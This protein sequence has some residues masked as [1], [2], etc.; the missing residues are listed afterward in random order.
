MSL[1]FKQFKKP[2]LAQLAYLVGDTKAGVAAIIDPCRDIQEYLDAARE[3]GLR[4]T[5]AIETHI[6]ADF[7]SGTLEM[8]NAVGAEIVGGKTDDYEF[9]L[10]QI[11]EGESIE[12]GKVRLEALHT[13]GHTPEHMSFL[14]FD[15]EQGEEPVGVFTGDT[16]FNLDVGRPDLVGDDGGKENARDLY[17][18]IF[19][20]LLPLGDRVE[21]YPCHGAGSACGKSIGD[22]DQS[23]IGNEKKFSEALKERTEQEFVDWL[24]DSMPEPPT[25]YSRL[26]KVNAKGAALNGVCL[27]PPEPLDPEKFEKLAGKSNHLILDTR[28]MLA[29]G[30]GHIEGALNIPLKPQLVSWAGWMLDPET[31]LLLIVESERDVMPLREHLFRIGIDKIDGYLHSGMESWQNTAR[32]LQ[33]IKQWTVRELERN[34]HDMDLT[35]LDVRADEEWEA[36]RIPGAIHQYVP[37]LEENI[38]EVPSDKPVATYCG[39]G[40]RAT[41]A[42]SILKKHGFEVINIPG[43]WKAWKAADLP[44]EKKKKEREMAGKS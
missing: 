20:K 4:I 6:H 19:E 39:T 7:V 25:H 5:H 2:G 3:A 41:I 23:T 43:S 37:H 14:L 34:R 28:D 29:F 22:R 26:K 12:L 18:S 31:H 17:K 33:S 36:G 16:L 40:Y 1:F 9:D 15:S 24:L 44:V 38:K 42:A 11:A 8:K 35:I 21:I 27:A 10:T 30:G 32:P 13:P